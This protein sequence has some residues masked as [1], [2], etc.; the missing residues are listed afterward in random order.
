MTDWA[1]LNKTKMFLLKEIRSWVLFD[2]DVTR[3]YAWLCRNVRCGVST[4]AVNKKNNNNIK[5]IRKNKW[6]RIVFS[7]DMF[8]QK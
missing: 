3:E 4:H 1:T 7:G 8:I 2:V 6:Q 5:I